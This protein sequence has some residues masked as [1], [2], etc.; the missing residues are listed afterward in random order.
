[1][2]AGSFSVEG[3]TCLLYGSEAP[4]VLLLQTGGKEENEGVPSV[5]AAVAA[6]TRTPFLLSSLAID[7]WNRELS[8]WAAPPVFGQ[9]SF[10][11]GGGETLAF[12]VERLL[13]AIR[14]RIGLGEELPVI[15]GGYSLAGLFA[16]WCAYESDRFGA[17]AAVSPSVWFPGWLDY[18]RARTPE[19]RQ[20]YLSL[21]DREER[22]RNR[23]M[24][25][26]GD[27]IR[28]QERLLRET[29]GV[30]CTLEW[31]PGNHFRD[32]QERCAK[33]YFWCMRRLLPET[34]Q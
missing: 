21:G 34:E 3:R 4:A 32:A 14:T 6:R 19:T 18:A 16:L 30:G 20:I 28:E 8:P 15:L 2:T 25:S 10:G 5:A 12:I 13:P 31:N 11:D 9:E 1:M 17:V 29:P 26:V 22:T 7:D 23:V 27:C 24:A 33:G